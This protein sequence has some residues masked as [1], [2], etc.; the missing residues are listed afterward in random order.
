MHVINSKIKGAFCEEFC[1]TLCPT[2]TKLICDITPPPGKQLSA[3][4]LSTQQQI[5][6]TFFIFAK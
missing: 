5:K 3:S 4:S 2:I 6:V 1:V